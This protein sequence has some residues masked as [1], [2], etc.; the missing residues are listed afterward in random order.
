MRYNL[1]KKSVFILTIILLIGTSFNITVSKSLTNLYFENEKNRQN[2]GYGS[3]I[4][5]TDDDFNNGTKFNINVS[6]DSFFLSEKTSIL[7]ETILGPESFE[8]DWPPN[9]WLETGEW[10]KENDRSHTGEYSADHDG[11]LLGSSGVLNSPSMDTSGATTNAVYIEFWTF[12]EGADESEY[13]LEY[14]DGNNWNFIT[15]LDNIGQGSWEKYTEKVTDTKYFTINFRIRWNVISLDLDEHVYVDDVQ[16][17]LEKEEIEGYVTNGS[18]ISQTHDTEEPTPEYLNLI[19]FSDIPTETKVESWVRAAGTESGL[20]DATW[21]SNITQVP[22]KQWVQWRINLT[23]NQIST[24]TVFEV[25]LTWY[26]EEFPVPDETFVDDDF[27]ENTP[28]WGYDHFDNIQDGVDAVNTSGTVNINSGTY[29]ENVI[30]QRSMTLIGENQIT[31]IVNGNFSGSVISII[32]SIVS[33]S[34][35]KVQNSGSDLTDAGISAESSKVILS[36]LIIQDNQHGI[37]LIGAE[38]SD[39]FL[40]RIL[41]NVNSGIALEVNSNYNWIAGNTISNNNIGVHLNIATG[42]EITH[43][44][45]GSNELWNKIDNN[46]YG[47]FSS[48]ASNNNNIYHNNL[49]ENSQN[50]HDEG[51]NYWDDGE[52]GNYWDDYTGEDADGDGVGDTPYPIPGGDNQDNYPMMIP[53][54]VDLEPPEVHI[55]KPQDDYLYVNIFDIIVFEIPI[56]LI[57]FNTLVIGKIDIEVYAIDNITGVEK[58]EFYINGELW[59]TDPTPPYGCTWDQ[60]VILFPYEVKVIAYDIVGNQG[61]DTKIVWKLG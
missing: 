50:A 18:L 33:I 6:K 40:N 34:G 39:I 4:Q 26:Y 51:I 11:T 55:T 2:R 15:R 60:F 30:I 22:H 13:N 36:S 54:G 46:N 1:L 12:S 5:T 23:G 21:Y 56:R 9:G 58:V 8:S 3:W 29:N 35:L 43:Y 53:N 19:N 27:D 20:Q 57:L 45:D 52:R 42:N 41:N 7:N 32:D 14:F 38:N 31:T 24:P 44:S 49:M 10:N 59:D 16:V 61:S 28:G 25:N 47:I 48:V 37:L 17:I